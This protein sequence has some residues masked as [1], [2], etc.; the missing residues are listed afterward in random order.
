M[1]NQHSERVAQ[2]DPNQHIFHLVFK[3]QQRR[4]KAGVTLIEVLIVVAIMAMIAGGV[5][6]FAM[7]GSIQ[8]KKDF[9]AT[10]VRELRRVAGAWQGMNSSASCPTLVDLQTAKLMDSSAPPDDP[11]GTPFELR[12][13]GDEIQA[14]SLGPDKQPNTPDDIAV[15]ENLEAS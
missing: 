15:P 10:Q 2:I 13:I 14:R 11:W 4:H 9:A 3:A 5:A 1:P 8:A 6:M 12:C 7:N